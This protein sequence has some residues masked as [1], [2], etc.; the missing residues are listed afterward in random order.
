MNPNNEKFIHR[1]TITLSM[2]AA[3]SSFG[4]EFRNKLIENEAY[5]TDIMD[6]HYYQSPEPGEVVKLYGIHP[7]Q[8]RQLVSMM[9]LKNGMFINLFT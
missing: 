9:K 5:D 4:D 3:T 8:D 6:I 1:K 7:D 2:D